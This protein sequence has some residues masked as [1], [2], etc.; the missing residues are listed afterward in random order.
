MPQFPEVYPHTSAKQNR[1]GEAE[2]G[3]RLKTKGPSGSFR[4]ERS[5]TD[6]ITTLR[7]IIEQSIEWNSPV[8]TNFIDFDSLYRE[9]IL[10][11]NETLWNTREVHIN[12]QVQSSDADVER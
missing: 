9:T 2:N 8:Y 5:Y 1:S 3:T 6:Q 12:N 11:A 7:I 4:Q 10:D